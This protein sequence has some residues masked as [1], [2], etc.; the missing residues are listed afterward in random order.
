MIVNYDCKMF[1]EQAICAS[2]SIRTLDLEIM[3]WVT[4]L[5]AACK[6]FTAV[7]KSSLNKLECL[8]KSALKCLRLIE[9]PALVLKGLS[10][11]WVGPK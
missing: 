4:H 7:T 8:L 6:L 11:T 3:S 2:G 9:K 5:V 1:I 10:N